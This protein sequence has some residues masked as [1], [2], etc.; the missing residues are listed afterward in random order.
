MCWYADRFLRL[1]T[2]RKCPHMLKSEQRELRNSQFFNTG[3][4][5][6]LWGWDRWGCLVWWAPHQ[7]ETETNLI[8]SPLRLVSHYTLFS[9]RS[10]GK[11]IS[12]QC[13]PQTGATLAPGVFPSSPECPWKDSTPLSLQS[14]LSASQPGIKRIILVEILQ[15]WSTKKFF[16]ELFQELEIIKKAKFVTKQYF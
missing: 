7:S 1:S 5:R 3:P 12:F 14:F 15:L 10:F 11:K 4:T 8:P 2:I 9:G 13:S 16:Q 6:T